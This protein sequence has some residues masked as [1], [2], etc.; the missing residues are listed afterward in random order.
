GKGTRLRSEHLLIDRASLLTLSAPEMTVL[1]GG[2]R[3]LGANSGQSPLG[4]LTATPGV[5]TN[6]FF[7]NLLDPGTAWTASN[8][9]GK[10]SVAEIFEGRD[11]ASGELRWTASR[12]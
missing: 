11:R 6:D 9:S 3:V 4:V 7:V 8:A 5:L 12:V 1:I 10:A 2:L